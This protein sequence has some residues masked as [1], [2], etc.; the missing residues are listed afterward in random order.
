MSG[1]QKT[2]IWTNK[3]KRPREE[4]EEDEE[5]KEKEDRGL[6]EKLIKIQ[7]TPNPNVISNNSEKEK[8]LKPIKLLKF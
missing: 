7:S 3:K 4:D 2:S 6:N 8:G 1:I 5:G